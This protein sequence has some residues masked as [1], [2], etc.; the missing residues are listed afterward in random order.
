MAGR[1]ASD[2]TELL[3][4]KDA[5]ELLGVCEMTL[6]RWDRSGKFKAH[7]HPLNGYRLYK[8]NDLMRLLRQIQG[9]LPRRE[10]QL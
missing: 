7:R 10:I 2:S 6:R 1:T 5:A 8:R 9:Q 4:I 3:T